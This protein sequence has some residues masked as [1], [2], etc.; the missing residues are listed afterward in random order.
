VYY[1]K[2]PRDEEILTMP[3]EIDETW[4]EYFSKPLNPADGALNDTYS[5]QWSKDVHMTAEAI[6]AREVGAPIDKA[7][8]GKA[9]GT[10]V[11]SNYF[12][13]W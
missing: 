10:D 13:K 5:Q 4:M 9:P 12:Y 6:G 2:D 8:Q 3:A 7:N 1:I 11:I